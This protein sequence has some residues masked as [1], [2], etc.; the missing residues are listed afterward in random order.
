MV[1]RSNM[2]VT[3]NLSGE[4][5]PLSKLGDQDMNKMNTCGTQAA[6]TY[7]TVIVHRTISYKRQTK[8]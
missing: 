7:L 4:G 2:W 1:T 3:D 5:I 6:V 8:T